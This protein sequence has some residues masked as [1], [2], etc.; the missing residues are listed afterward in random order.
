MGL[1]VFLDKSKPPEENDL[2]TVLGE[3]K[4]LWDELKTFVKEQCPDIIEDWKHYGK[5]SGWT[6]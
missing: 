3:T 4:S 5:N 2:S 6:M 1:S